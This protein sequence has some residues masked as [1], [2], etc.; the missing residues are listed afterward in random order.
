[1]AAALNRI[2]WGSLLRASHCCR[3]DGLRLSTAPRSPCSHLAP[4]KC[5]SSSSWFMTPR[6]TSWSCCC[7]F[8]CCRTDGLRLSTAPRS[9]GF[10]SVVALPQ[11]DHMSSVL[12]SSYD[13]LAQID[14]RN[15]SQVIFYDAVIPGSTVLAY[16]NADHWA[17]GVPL[18]R[19]HPAIA[20][21]FVDK[22]AFP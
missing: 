10:Y 21:M 20:S 13:K 8:H 7:T 6:R 14:P 12:R 4:G 19:S 22:N 18:A 9:I 11:P 5:S 3:T 15:D 17:V 2:D 16:L 1:A